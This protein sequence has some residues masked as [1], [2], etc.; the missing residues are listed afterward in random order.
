MNRLTLL[1]TTLV[2]A[3]SA[4][5]NANTTPQAEQPTGPEFE[6]FDV[7]NN[8]VISTHEAVRDALLQS[9]FKDIDSNGDQKLSKEEYQSYKDAEEKK[10][11]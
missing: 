4:A 1:V 2:L 9:V 5:V 6:V 11:G 7:D 8:G 3:N 10:P